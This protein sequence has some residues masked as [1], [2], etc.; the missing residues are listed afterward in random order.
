MTVAHWPQ[1]FVGNTFQKSE[2]A[3][4]EGEKGL[5]LFLRVEDGNDKEGDA[6]KGF[7][8]TGNCWLQS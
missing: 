2:A 5:R 6:G 4:V 3:L 7:R 8:L 1:T